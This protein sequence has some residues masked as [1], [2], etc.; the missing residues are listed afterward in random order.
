MDEDFI[1]KKLMKA[2]GK[3][4]TGRIP[5]GLDRLAKSH[6]DKTAMH[7]F[8][9]ELLKIGVARPYP[10]NRDG[11]TTDAGVGLKPAVA[12]DMDPGLNGILLSIPGLKKEK[13]KLSFGPEEATKVLQVVKQKQ[14]PRAGMRLLGATPE[15]GSV[16]SKTPGLFGVLSGRKATQAIQQSEELA[17][18]VT[19]KYAPSR[20]PEVESGLASGR[21][22]MAPVTSAVERSGRGVFQNGPS[23]KVIS[24]AISQMPRPL[25][26]PTLPRLEG[27]KQLKMLEAITKGHELSE[28]QVRPGMSFKQFGHN[29]PDVILREHNAVTT[30]PS[31]YAPT[32]E[33]MKSLRTRPYGEQEPLRQFGIEYGKSP[34]LSRHARKRITESLE[35]QNRQIL[36]MPMTKKAEVSRDDALEAVK[37]L[38]KKTGLG[39]YATNATGLAAVSPIASATAKAVAAGASAPKGHGLVKGVAAFRGALN[40]HDVVE[41]AVGGALGGTAMT[42]VKNTGEHR[43]A[44]R[45]LQ[46]YLESANR[47]D[48]AKLQPELEK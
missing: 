36:E 23:Q 26:P 32:A 9:D 13:K 38:N 22:A 35:Q 8:H 19:N 24:T 39:E 30:L 31:G 37:R 47:R 11:T 20:L 41:K 40:K 17:R 34:R 7:A 21:Q 2:V 46:T 18:H 12:S 28:T 43:Q 6:V 4:R 16:L 14:M 3:T 1:S 27:G 10:G 5:I 29:S 42:A 45:T 15:A 48:K 33:Y 25:R 44:K